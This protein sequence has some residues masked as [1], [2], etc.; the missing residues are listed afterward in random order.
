MQTIFVAV[1]ALGSAYFLLRKRRFDYFTLAFFSS[2]IYFLPGFYGA[3]SYSVDG[4]WSASPIHPEAYGVMIFV[5]VSILLAEKIA[6]RI[7]RN[8]AF[9]NTLLP[10]GELVPVLLTIAAFA[11]VLGLLITVG[12]DL[13]H[14]DKA[15]VLESLNRWH[16]LFYAAA[17]L[18]VALSFELR[19][20][21]Y[22]ALCLMLLAFDLYV[23]FR[24]ALSMAILSILVLL[25]HARGQQR[26]AATSWRML[27]AALAFGLS[28]FVYKYISAAAKLGMWDLV[29]NTLS[30]PDQLLLVFAR[31]EPFVV[32]QTLNEVITQRFTT[33]ADHILS[34]L[35]QFMLFAPELDA[36]N[37][38]FN[39]L[40]QSALFPE[41]T[42]GLA[43]NI[44][45]QMWSAGGW[46]LLVLFV[47]VFNI[48]IAVGNATLR[49]QCPVI[50]A[51]FA[52][53]FCYWVFYIHRNDLGYTLNLGKR[54]LLL[55]IAAI[56]LAS[57]LKAALRRPRLHQY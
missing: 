12:S 46:P 3:T 19:Q 22:L 26:L 6:S 8:A 43:S 29:W 18:G 55:L 54:H 23:G 25:L 31:S 51:G 16:I 49:A 35:Y 47:L 48:L 7:A 50:R 36:T 4:T 13:F 56:V 2:L 57:I 14:S 41:V 45:A 33:N 10:A 20:R 21:A 52:P 32:Q 27:L 11:G 30:E 38:G 15:L 53:I 34:S 37:V 39:S 42:Y 44:W 1:A 28:M 24:S 17:T 40:F 5:V 9:D